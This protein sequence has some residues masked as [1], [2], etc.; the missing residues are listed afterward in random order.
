MGATL[1]IWIDTL[2]QYAAG[3]PLYVALALGLATFLTE[4]GALIAGSLAVGAG[5]LD[6]SLTILALTAG[7]I[8]GD[9]GLYAVGWSARRVPFFMRFI[10]QRTTVKVKRWAKKRET[11][12]LFLTR[13]V[14][15]TRLVTYMSFGFLRLSIVRFTVVLTI[16]GFLWVSLMVLFISE[17]QQATDALG[18][19]NALILTLVTATILVL[20][21][22]RL[23]ARIPL[24]QKILEA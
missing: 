19:T 8:V 4:D 17:I 22:P 15:G 9:L 23:I 20:A 13:F 18:Q 11:T 1:D 6:P 14:P 12:L 5:A 21:V 16:A 2:L 24:A 7:I 3:D 10:P